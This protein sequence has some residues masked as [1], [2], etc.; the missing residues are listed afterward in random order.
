VQLGRDD[1]F[2]FHAASLRE[3]TLSEHEEPVLIAG[4]VVLPERAGLLRFNFI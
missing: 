3:A 1:I 2:I 4:A